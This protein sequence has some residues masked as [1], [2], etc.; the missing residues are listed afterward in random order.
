MTVF[1][2]AP[3]H[4]QKAQIVHREI[5]QIRSDECKPEMDLAEPVVPH[6]SGDL[7]IPV[8]D[9]PKNHQNRRNAHHHMKMRDD[10]ICAGQRN[11]HADVAEKQSGQPAIYEREDETDGKQH[12]HREVDIAAPQREHP[13]VDFDRRRN[14]NDEG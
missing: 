12:R 11:V 10:E 5:D 13:V 14:G 4:P 2:V 3:R 8:I 1:I 7:G 6:P 9:S